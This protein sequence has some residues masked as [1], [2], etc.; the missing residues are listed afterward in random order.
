MFHFDPCWFSFFAFF[1]FEFFFEP[2]YFCQ[3]RPVPGMPNDIYN[4]PV[5]DRPKRNPGIPMLWPTPFFEKV[6]RS[7]PL[8]KDFLHRQLIL[9]S[10]NLTLFSKILFPK[11][12]RLIEPDYESRLANIIHVVLNLVQFATSKCAD[13]FARR[14]LALVKIAYSYY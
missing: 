8:L 10:S 1:C 11:T 7:G 4:F 13:S 6:V 2:K 12:A 5:D 14:D 9:C 3:Y